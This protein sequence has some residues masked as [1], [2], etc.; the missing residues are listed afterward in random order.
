VTQDKR[1]HRDRQTD[2]HHRRN[3][4]DS[5]KEK[6]VAAENEQLRTLMLKVSYTSTAVYETEEPE[7]DPDIGYIDF[8]EALI[9]A[10]A[11]FECKANV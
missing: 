3:K 5:G 8:P 4:K 2:H 7:H 6:A 9:A 1:L 10:I 11:G